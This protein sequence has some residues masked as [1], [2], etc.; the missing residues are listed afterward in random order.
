MA[1]IILLEDMAKSEPATRGTSGFCI[2]S[3]VTLQE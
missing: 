1:I 2:I 3:V